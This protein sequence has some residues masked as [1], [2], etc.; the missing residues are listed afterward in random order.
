MRHNTETTESTTSAGK[1]AS[2][3]TVIGLPLAGSRNDLGENIE[4][5][6]NAGP[7]REQHIDDLFEIEKPER[8]LQIAWIEDERAVAEAAAVFVVNVEQE[9]PQV[10]PRLE[11]FVEQQR[12][13]SRLA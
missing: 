4:F 12:H 11:N 2:C 13:A 8:Q 7:P 1:P 10:R 3:I 6:R 5:V 9:N